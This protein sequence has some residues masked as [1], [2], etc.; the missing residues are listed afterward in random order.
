[1]YLWLTRNVKSVCQAIYLS[2]GYDKPYGFVTSVEWQG[3]KPLTLARYSWPVY[4]NCQIASD[5]VEYPDGHC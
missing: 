1:M 5:C 4:P 3:G 2:L